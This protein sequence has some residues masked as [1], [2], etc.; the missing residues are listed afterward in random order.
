M[1]T[2]SLKYFLVVCRN[3][4]QVSL[5]EEVILPLLQFSDHLRHRYVVVYH[6]KAIIPSVSCTVHKNDSKMVTCRHCSL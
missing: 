5:D 6:V 4:L 1:E 2:F 3:K